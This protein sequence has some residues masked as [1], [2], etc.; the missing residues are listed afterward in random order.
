MCCFQ[1]G[2]KRLFTTRQI[3]PIVPAMF[4]YIV[5]LNLVYRIY[6]FSVRRFVL[7]CWRFHSH[8]TQ[9]ASYPKINIG[10]EQRLHLILKLIWNRNTLMISTPIPTAVKLKFAYRKY[11]TTLITPLIIKSYCTYFIVLFV[12]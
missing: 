1:L 11:N 8:Q 10:M 4:S 12:L 9:A 2:N 3:D 7:I 5:T 6:E